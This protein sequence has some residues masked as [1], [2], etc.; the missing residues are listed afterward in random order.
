MGRKGNA[1][2]TRERGKT[3]LRYGIEVIISIWESGGEV[4]TKIRKKLAKDFSNPKSLKKVEKQ[5]FSQ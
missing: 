3:L 2:G 1:G 4:T 5:D